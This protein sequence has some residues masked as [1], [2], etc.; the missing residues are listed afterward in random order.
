[1]ATKLK[2]FLWMLFGSGL[3]V[4]LIISMN[5]SDQGSE[6]KGGEKKTS[7]EL[8]QKPKAKPQAAPK[9]KPKPQKPKRAQQA[10]MPDLSSALAGVDLGIPEFAMG[11]LMGSGSELIGDVSKDMTMT[12]ST[13]D[14]VPKAAERAPLEYPKAAKRKGIEGYVLFN[15]LIGKDG[16]VIRT[17]ILEAQPEGVFED[18]A[19]M[20]V[21]QWRFE[22]ATYKGE[23]VKVWAKQKIA[24]KFQ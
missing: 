15:L 7:L 3:M 24:F 8:A 10:P 19:T 16:K 17:K 6:Q 4:A 11:D 20:S 1:M 21:S 2:A 18:A 22:P 9:P 23:P 14:S 5:L 12:E 13:V